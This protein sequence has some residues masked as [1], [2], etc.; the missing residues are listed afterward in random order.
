ME[1]SLTVKT[2]A[3]VEPLTLAEAK[4]HLKVE[5]D[6]NDE[7][8]LIQ[9]LIVTARE[10][11]EN[12]CRRSVASRTYELRMDNWCTPIRLPRG[13]VTSLTHI[14]YVN[15]G[16]TLTTL[17]ADQ[18]QVDLYSTPPCIVPAYGVVWPT[19]KSGEINAIL[20]EYVAG[21]ATVNGFPKAIQSAMKLIV[22][23]L[24][25]NRELVVEKQTFE[26]PF[27]VKS[28]LAPYEVRDYSLE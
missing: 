27:A 24:Y 8:A 1:Y 21:Y 23:H 10:W 3:T 14:K 22:G 5:D 16:G 2:A 26:V 11:V 28:L 19:V 6:A 15:S 20:I 17:D 12:Y 4:M 7:D 25:A 18:Y 9:D 13:P